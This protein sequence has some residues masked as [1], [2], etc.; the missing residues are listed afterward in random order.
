M[1]PVAANQCG[2][3]S[4]EPAEYK[5]PCG[6]VVCEPH[7]ALASLYAVSALSPDHK[8]S[9]MLSLG[10]NRSRLSMAFIS[11]EYR[12]CNSQIGC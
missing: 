7:T 4:T 6:W 3:S 11:S 1:G 9:V 10:G 8:T 5:R 12:L 2:A